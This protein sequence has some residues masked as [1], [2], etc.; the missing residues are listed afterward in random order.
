MYKFFLG[1]ITAACMSAAAQAG[2]MTNFVQVNSGL[3][4][5][6]G[7]GHSTWAMRVTADTDWTNADLDIQLDSGNLVHIAP[8]FLGSP[9]G[10]NNLGDTA[11]MAP[12]NNLGDVTGGFNGVA[13]FAGAHVETPT[14]IQTSW[15]TTETNDIGEFDIAMITLSSSANGELRFRTIAGSDVEDGGIG[16][17]EGMLFRVRDGGIELIPEPTTLVLA[18]LGICGVLGL[19]RRS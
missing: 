7:D 9:N 17:V 10:V 8:A 4:D 13:G 3:F 19:R 11:G 5:N 15:F 18:G 16:V 2:T 12:A 14:S 6:S 1:L